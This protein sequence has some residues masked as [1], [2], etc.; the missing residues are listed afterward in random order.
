MATKPKLKY[1]VVNGRNPLTNEVIQRP[2]IVERETLRTDDVVTYALNAGYVRG[3]FHDMR[4]ALNGFVEAIQQLGRD[5]KCVNLNDWLAIR[6]QLTGTVDETRQ[7][8]AANSYRVTITAL[9]ELKRDIGDFSWTNID[10]TAAVV[11]IDHIFASGATADGVVKDK[12]IIING[13]NLIYDAALGDS[14]EIAYTVDGE[15][16][17]LSLSPSESSAY[18]LTF[19]FPTELASV[20]AGTELTFTLKSRNGVADAATQVVT[21]KVTLLAA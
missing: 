16:K 3:Q 7:L 15:A 6:G 20:E 9:K 5:G 12:A 1:R 10:D 13:K 19:T 8:S 4:G 17:T 14:L 2:I 21:K 11:K 18:N